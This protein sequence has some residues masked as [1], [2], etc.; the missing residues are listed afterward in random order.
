MSWRHGTLPLLRFAP[1]CSTGVRGLIQDVRERAGRSGRG[2]R[3]GTAGRAVR[4]RAVRVRSEGCDSLAA[5]PAAPCARTA[6]DLQTLAAQRTGHLA[7]EHAGPGR[8]AGSR[9][10]GVRQ[11]AARLP[12]SETQAPLRGGGRADPC[13]ALRG[14]SPSREPST[15]EDADRSASCPMMARAGQPVKRRRPQPETNAR[16]NA[17]LPQIVHRFVSAFRCTR[18]C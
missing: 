5:A 13:R 17:L 11:H 10:C 2:I 9:A 12:R 1:V 6:G 18:G 15:N 7:R 3:R 14:T 8:R 16:S 4:L